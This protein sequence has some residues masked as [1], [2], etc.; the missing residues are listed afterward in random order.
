MDGSGF[1]RN[2]VVFTLSGLA[3]NADLASLVNNVAFQYGT[4]LSEPRIVGTPNP[5]SQVP[6]PATYALMGAGLIGLYWMKR[7]PC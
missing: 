5:P 7:K 6:E 3:N 4:A 1:I 2:S